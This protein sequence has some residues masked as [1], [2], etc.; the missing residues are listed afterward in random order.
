MIT[1]RRLSNSYELG[2]KLCI[3]ITEEEYNEFKEVC[4]ERRYGT[5]A[6]FIIISIDSG[7]TEEQIG[8][9]KSRI[10]DYYNDNKIKLPKT[11]ELGS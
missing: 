9:I 3:P 4:D 2:D 10:I 7:F 6:G 1:A 11:E 5:G 8:D